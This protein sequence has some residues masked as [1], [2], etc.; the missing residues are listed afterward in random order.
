MS[1]YGKPE[2]W[3]ERYTRYLT[4]NPETQNLSTGI[5]ASADSRILSQP[6]SIRITRSSMSEQ[7]TLDSAKKCWRK[8]TQ[9]SP[10]L[11]SAGWL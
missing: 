6:I 8:A 9:I 10:T 11:I 1:Q 3:D 2:Y 4:P 7:A 5:N